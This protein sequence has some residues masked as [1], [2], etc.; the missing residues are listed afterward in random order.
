V[1]PLETILYI[2]GD[3][4]LWDKTLSEIALEYITRRMQAGATAAAVA[5]DISF[6]FDVHNPQVSEWLNR[7]T[8]LM[9]N[10]VNDTVRES[11]R[12]SLVEGMENGLAGRDIEKLILESLGAERNEAGKLVA[13]EKLK[14]RAELI[15]R[16][17]YARAQNA[18][19]DWQLRDA[20]ATRKVWRANPDACEFCA[21][22]DGKTI[23]AEDSFFKRGDRIELA[24]LE[25]G[26]N[27][28]TMKLD[29]S[30]T[31]YPPLHPNCVCSVE[32]DFD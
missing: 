7:Y 2:L 22:L 1:T 20:G 23:G 13:G 30:D 28:Q 15:E 31:D 11:I 16:T 25:E 9:A 21:E 17:E 12:T 14:Y 3:A 29:Y 10:R 32:Y 24:P 26:D 18:G 27:V 4:S 5:S 8:G 6:S 19:R